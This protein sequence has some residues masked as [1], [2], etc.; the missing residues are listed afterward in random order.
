MDTWDRKNILV[1]KKIIVTGGG[2]YIGSHTVVE[3]INSG[4][5]PIIIDNLCNTSVKNIKGVE[6]IT[7]E[8]IKWYNSD[9]TNKIAMDKVFHEEGKIEG[10]IHFAAYKSVEESVQTHKSITIIILDP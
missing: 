6:K 9:C 10:V 7:G 1:K 8:E 3:L 5:I 2:G 4:F